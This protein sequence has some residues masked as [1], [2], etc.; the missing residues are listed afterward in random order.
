MLHCKYTLPIEMQA[1]TRLSPVCSTVS[2]EVDV[3]ILG[4]ERR[5]ERRGWK[6]EMEDK[7]KEDKEEPVRMDDEKK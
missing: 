3:C 2:S 6:E 4:E 5:Q 1:G 7:D